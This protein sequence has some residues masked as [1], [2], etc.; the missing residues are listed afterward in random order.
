MND[1]NAR[2][3]LEIQGSTSARRRDMQQISF[4][5]TGSEV[6]V[7]LHSIARTVFVHTWLLFTLYDV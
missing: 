1:P 7:L 2:C 6:F 4:I 5:L 3:D